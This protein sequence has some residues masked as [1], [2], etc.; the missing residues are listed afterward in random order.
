[1]KAYEIQDFAQTGKLRLVD[2]PVP[3]PPGPGQALVRIRATG[4]NA[5]DLSIMRGLQFGQTV[6]PTRI[7]LSDNAG[8]V[9]AVG[10]GVTHVKP[11]D[12][13]TMTHY[14]RWL[15]GNWDV[16]MRAEDFALTLDGFLVEQAIVP[17]APLIRLPDSISHEEAATLQSA[18][19]TAWNAVVESGGV[20]AGQTVVT[21]GTGGVSVFCMQWAKM[22]GAR[23]IVTSSSDDKIARVK[24]LGADDG[25]NYRTTPLWAKAVMDLTGGRGADIVV[26][27]VGMSEVDQC[28]ESCVSGGR[29]MYVGANAVAPDRKDPVPQPLT[30]LPLLI[31]R[32]LTLKGVIVGSRAMFVNLLTQMAANKVQ[33]VI[34]RI[35]DFEQVNDAIAYMA[36]GDKIGKV[37]IRVQ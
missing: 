29:V 32:D 25:I 21:T 20:K 26:N 31:I 37:I 4:L 10:A 14:W 16:S 11:G 5:R 17:A 18:G 2:R 12:R 24:A 6:A 1:M 3:P 19:L 33:P 30:R 27:N 13:V 35:Y 28:L 9:I 23:V 34:D 15:D 7:P 36:G 22:L 8:D